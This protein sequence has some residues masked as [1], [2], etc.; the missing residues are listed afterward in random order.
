MFYF[1]LRVRIV[2]D[3]HTKMIRKDEMEENGWMFLKWRKVYYA[4]HA[5]KRFKFILAAL[6]NIR[7]VDF[8]TFA[9]GTCSSFLFI[10]QPWALGSMA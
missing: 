1:H 10:Y 7:E 3:P 5:K 2:L 6:R 9:M 4:L 8:H